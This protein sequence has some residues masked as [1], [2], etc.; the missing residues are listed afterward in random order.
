MSGPISGD[1]SNN[2]WWEYYHKHYLI[3]TLA[4]IKT[5]PTNKWINK[6]ASRGYGDV[7]NGL[8]P[9]QAM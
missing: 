9:A 1:M 3:L 2:R 6:I 4:M 5:R 8:I 7:T